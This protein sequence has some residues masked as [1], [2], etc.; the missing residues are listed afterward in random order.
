MDWDA[1]AWD[2]MGWEHLLHR[3]RDRARMAGLLRLTVFLNL[4]SYLVVN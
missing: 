4:I 2:G 3:P 1:V